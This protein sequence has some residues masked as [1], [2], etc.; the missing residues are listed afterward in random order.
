M[1]FV[2]TGDEFCRRVDNALEGVEDCTKVVDDLLVWRKTYEE[3]LEQVRQV[4]YRLRRHC[5]TI[6]RKKFM[7]ANPTARFCGYNISKDVVSV[8]PATLRELR[9][10]WY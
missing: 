1:G 2:S 4:L 8:D 7:F 9:S 3:H 6:N 5:I 10:F